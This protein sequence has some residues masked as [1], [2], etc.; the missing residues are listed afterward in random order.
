MV[1][2]VAVLVLIL[3]VSTAG[4]YYQYSITHE[5]ERVVVDW[6]SIQNTQNGTTSSWMVEVQNLGTTPVVGVD[7]LRV[8]VANGS[9]VMRS[10]T[11]LVG[12]GNI[13]PNPFVLENGYTQCCTLGVVN[14][15]ST[16]PHNPGIPISTTTPIG[17]QQLAYTEDD[18]VTVSE[19]PGVQTAPTIGQ[20]FHDC[21]G[22]IP[23]TST[24]QCTAVIKFTFADGS[25]TTIMSPIQTHRL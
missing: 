25:T 16:W 14:A 17:P 2:V 24:N 22:L 18:R 11:G 1:T 4:A 23:S 3:V 20:F 6:D 5:P 8:D 13:P 21:S 9:Q 7:V 12:L 15:P 10:F 19:A